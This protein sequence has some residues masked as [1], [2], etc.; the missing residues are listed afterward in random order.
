[1]TLRPKLDDKKFKMPP[2][3]PSECVAT[4][5]QLQALRYRQRGYTFNHISRLLQCSE[6]AVRQLLKKALQAYEEALEQETGKL[7]MIEMAR[8]D[9]LLAGAES[10][11][12]LAGD[13][14]EEGLFVRAL[15]GELPAIDRV[16]KLLE[17]RAKLMGLDKA[18][19][20]I[21]SAQV[22]RHEFVVIDPQEERERIRNERAI[23]A[24]VIP[25]PTGEDKEL[26]SGESVFS[27]IPQ[28]E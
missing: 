17:R 11:P 18:E 22:V 3:S 16:I 5:R 14:Q 4:E 12:S 21:G 13:A 25:N 20:E 6:Q 27:T 15:K 24:E 7:W 8:I 23:D 28:L 26:P 19:K 2:N 9:A 10:D 1:M